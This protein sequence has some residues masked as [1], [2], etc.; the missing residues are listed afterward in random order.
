MTTNVVNLR[1]AKYD[2]YIGR[3]GKGQTSIWGNPA[4]VGIDGTQ[5]EC[6]QLFENLM[7]KRI[8]ENPDYWLGEL[9]KLKGKTLG[10][11][12]KPRACHGDIIVKLIQEYFPD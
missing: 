8:K 12:C 9:K 3:P 5:G 11:F 6:V 2:V 7:R 1:A 4:R 10:C